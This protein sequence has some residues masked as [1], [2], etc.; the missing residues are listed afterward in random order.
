VFSIN[1][2]K[3]HTKISLRDFNEN[4][5]IEDIFR[6]AI[7]NRSI[8]EIINDNRVTVTKFPRHNT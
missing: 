3:N 5:T 4:V 8:Y 7:G 1:S 6:P 2:P